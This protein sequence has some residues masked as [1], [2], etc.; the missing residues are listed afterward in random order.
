VV[1]PPPLFFNVHV[2]FL[3]ATSK[4]QII[5]QWI[6]RSGSA[7]KEQLEYWSYGVLD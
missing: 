6:Q 4:N 2:N 5:R 3:S 1:A 7:R